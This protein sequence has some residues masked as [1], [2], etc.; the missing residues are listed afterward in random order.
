MFI[1]F[2]NELSPEGGAWSLCSTEAAVQIVRRLA[3]HEWDWKTARWERIAK[4]AGLQSERR[5]PGMITFR[6]GEVELIAYTDDRSNV[7]EA[8]IVVM[9]WEAV[10]D[11][12]ASAHEEQMKDV[13]RE[14]ELEL[15]KALGTH[16]I[17]GT[18]ASGVESSI[19]W[20]LSGAALRPERTTAG[21]LPG[22]VRLCLIPAS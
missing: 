3:Q 14:L 21:D 13:F 5:Q 10:E 12:L 16:L 17:Q 15:T 8:E 11:P 1:A 19:T 7:R 2:L 9:V 4:R 20:R 22:E 18:E 6:D